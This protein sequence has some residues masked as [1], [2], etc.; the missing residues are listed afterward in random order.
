MKPTPGR[1]FT[2]ALAS[3]SLIGPLAV[4][5]FLPVIPAVKAALGLS[6][7]LAQFTFSIALFGMAFA[8]LVY[9]SLSDRYGRRPLLLSGLTLFLVGSAFSFT[10]N[11]ISTL[12]AGRLLQAV[13]AGCGVTLA[14]AI[15][16]D[17][18]GP[19][20]LVKVIAYLTMFYTI[21]PMISPMVGG[22]LIDTLG[23]RSVFGFALLVGSV[24]LIGCYYAVFESRPPGQARGQGVGVL[25]SYAELFGHLRFS[26][27]VLQTGFSTGT[28]LVAATAASTLMKELLQRP[29]AEFGIYFLMFPFGFLIGNFISTRL[30][31][32][33]ANETMVLAGSILSV[34]AVMAETGVL[35]AGHLTPLAFFVPGFFITMA[36]GI[37]LPFCQAGAMAT[38]PQMAGTAAG[39]GVFTQYFGGAAFTQLYGLIADGTPGPLMMSMLVSAVLGLAA[40]A[41]PFAMLRTGSRISKSPRGDGRDGG[42]Q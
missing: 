5:L 14:R 22:I 18:Y 29:S 16:A 13:G 42:E 8:T 21:G 24:I 39:I 12:A 32:R 1:Q 37:S 17:V 26:A 6:D 9:G 38:N 11:S 3:I 35:L 25:R 41:I 20:R 40:G 2:L 10:A 33:V 28:F 23:W 15:A 36:Q 27:F 34:A 4:H 7:A 19:T 30:S 31:G